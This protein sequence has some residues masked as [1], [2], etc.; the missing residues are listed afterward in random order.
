MNLNISIGTKSKI[1]N[2][3]LRLIEIRDEKQKGCMIALC[4]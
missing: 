1:P 3:V 4:S 2:E